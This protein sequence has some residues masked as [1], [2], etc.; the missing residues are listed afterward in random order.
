M[1]GQRGV[2]VERRGRYRA[3]GVDGGG[4]GVL[5][6]EG[7]VDIASGDSGGV[8]VVDMGDVGAVGGQGVLGSLFV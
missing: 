4:E 6:G 8:P 5:R 2:G 1:E 3:V 7:G